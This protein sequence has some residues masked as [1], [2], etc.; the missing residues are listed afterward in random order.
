MADSAHFPSSKIEVR[1][2]AP[3]FA[4]ADALRLAEEL[5]GIS[6]AAEPLESERDRNFLIE[7]PTGERFVLKIAGRAE[8]E[9]ALD[10]QNRALEH[11]AKEAPALALPR[12]RRTKTGAA[13]ARTA[14]KDG[15]THFVRMVGYI[16]GKLL[17]ECSPHTP[18]LLRSLGAAL[19]ALDRGLQ[20][21]DHPAAVRPL[22]W[23]LAQA[24]WI[25]D[26]LAHIEGG[27]RRARVEAILERFEREITPALASMRRSVI[28]NDAN[29]HNV[30]VG[31]GDA[32]TRR[33]RGVI[34]F[35]DMV[36][37]ATVAEAAVGAAYAMMGKAD[38][39]A[40]AANVIRGYHEEFP[41]DESEIELLF[42]LIETRLATTVTNSAYQRA[43][44]PGN[45]YLTVSEAPAWRLLEQ[46]QEIS[47]R[48]AL[49]A[50]RHACGLPACSSATAVG[51]WLRENAA[52]FGKVIEPDPRVAPCLIFD[53][54]AGSS[55][56]GT[57]D[58][59]EDVKAATETI[60]SRM[61]GAGAKA[62]IGRYNE[63]RAVYRAPGFTAEGN[64]GPE[65]RTIHLG[66]DLF[67]EPGS[68]VF[69][70]LD[71]VVHS[72]AN[73]AAPLDYGPTIVLEHRAANGASFY[74][75]YGHLSE[76]SLEGLAPGKTVRRGE[77]I[78]RVGESRVNGGWPPHLHFQIVLDM[79]DRKGDSPGVARPGERGLWLE[80][81]PDPNLI[82]RIPALDA[83]SS[84]RTEMTR[85]EIL[86]ERK[87]RIGASLSVSYRRPLEIVRGAREWLF[88]ETGRPYLDCVNNVA[89]VGH[90]HPRVVR[91]A[92]GQM[93]TLNTN[94]RYL[95]EK[96]VRYAERLT[97]TLPEPLRVCFFV[98][99]GSEA[100]ELALR[101]AR[102]R[103]GSK[104]TI[105]L[106]AAYHGNTTS[107]V[108]I[109][110]YKF[111]GPGG[112][113]AP[114]HVHKI[115]LPDVYR[116]AYRR[117]DPEAGAKYAAHVARAI[118]EIELRGMK[119]GAFI[120]E[121]MPGCGGQIV[122]PK[123][124][125]REAYRHVR[126]AGGVTIA[127]E[128]QT[129]FGRVGT[130]F[131]AFETQNVVPDIVTM[132][133]P[134]G[135][136]HPMG[137]VVTTPEIAASFAN[138]MEYFNTFG[139][140]PVSCAIGL[141]VLD[142]IRDERLQENAREV[143]DT[144]LERLRGLAQRHAIIGD[145]RGSGLFLGIE[146]VRDPR[147]LEPAAEEAAYIVNRVREAGILLS[148]DGPLHNAIKIKPPLVFT[149]ADAD[150]L[151]STLE[152][153][154]GEDFLSR[155]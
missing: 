91:A 6:G 8:R 16:P 139:G 70:P 89:H 127:D 28:Y 147:T 52:Q 14:A 63:A 78:A 66:L 99:S 152:R 107:L 81:S 5:Y 41:L 104:Q 115:P 95:H 51:Q 146:L 122:F 43:A 96:L 2:P 15:T 32:W 125:L 140:N 61:K 10:L 39:I 59:W 77:Q 105:V 85:E 72:F 45:D 18:E 42:P 24:G 94:T 93:A 49:A 33:V 86:A 108:E 135:N 145:V 120:A 37:T 82:A 3:E 84:A 101:L 34:D 132:G 114:P 17:A 36:R 69:A 100:N 30:I 112:E 138:G 92:Q 20:S 68:P 73:N 46:L 103:T 131:W 106:D 60:F 119:L 143:G 1:F 123:N 155:G 9:E 25:R 44:E 35:G 128:V 141:A 90:G 88:D 74:T 7:T 62:G 19:G 144:L 55:E 142:A 76:E 151:A 64:D 50:F 121:S 21:F 113:G 40:A 23:D 71:A 111:D 110:P 109:S 126:E 38:P 87:R 48:F 58:E 56:T 47:P 118:R 150:F 154:L 12:L 54:S 27:H 4:E 149:R 53:L 130:H 65:W 79:L 98:C 116:G 11:L 83:A 134:I 97:K 31:P 13:I 26:Y 129:G 136:G 133:K 75:L 124:F 137:A 148:T 22:K 57:Y 102:A 117:D 153:V 80:L 29:D 67:V